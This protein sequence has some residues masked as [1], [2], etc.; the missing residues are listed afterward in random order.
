M[1]DVKGYLELEESYDKLNDTNESLSDP[2]FIEGFLLL[3]IVSDVVKD[4][5]V[6]KKVH[7]D[8][9]P[10]YLMEKHKRIALNI[11]RGVNRLGFHIDVDYIEKNI[12][13]IIKRVTKSIYR[14]DKFG[15]DYK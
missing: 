12:D 6:S 10:Q 9:I 3:K 4:I 14:E 11:I 2:N 1:E 15:T 7:I 13:K 8:E 5:V